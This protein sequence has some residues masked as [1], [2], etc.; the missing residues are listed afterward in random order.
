MKP[1]TTGPLSSYRLFG[2]SAEDQW[3]GL[4][5][6]R[7]VGYHTRIA[8]TGR[9][10]VYLEFVEIAPWNWRL[11]QPAQ[12]PRLKGIGSQ[13]FELAVRWSD[14]LGFHGRIGLHSL[15]QADAFYRG[16]CG[17]TEFGSDP[18]YHNLRYFELD[19]T[20]VRT[21]LEEM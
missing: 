5:L 1:Y 9:E 6:G 4:L 11:S 12:E 14:D 19:E 7:C 20:H 10:L 18:G 8:P 21:F 16:H 17:M 3:Q 2:I 13:L 15:P